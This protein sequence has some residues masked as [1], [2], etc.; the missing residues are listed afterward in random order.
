[1]AWSRRGAAAGR[2]RDVAEGEITRD[3]PMARSS[4]PLA[5]PVFVQEL[6]HVHWP[7]SHAELLHHAELVPVV[8]AV[9]E[10]SVGELNNRDGADVDPAAGGGNP[11]PAALVGAG[12]AEAD[13][14]LVAFGHH[15][16]NHKVHVRKGIAEVAHK[17]LELRR[18]VDLG[19]RGSQA[20]ANGS[21]RKQ[22]VNGAFAALIPDLF[23][24]SPDKLFV[25]GVH[26]NT[27]GEFGRTVA[28]RL[29][30]VPARECGALNHDHVIMRTKISKTIK[31][32][33]AGTL[34][35]LSPIL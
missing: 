18:A 32:F 35:Q 12:H 11:Q 14:H 16:F 23:K 34:W 31:T 22:L 21:G 2:G 20:K 6:V 3:H 13:G 5:G 33:E 25:V 8:P 19:L 1:M 30:G 27:S 24:P 4:D 29:A 28:Q 7:T 26:G 10:L 17:R 9:G 15:V